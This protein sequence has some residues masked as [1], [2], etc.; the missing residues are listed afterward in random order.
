M[1]KDGEITVAT[2]YD[3]MMGQFGV[4]RGLGGEYPKDYD[5][6]NQPFTPAWQENIPA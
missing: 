5:D 4:S 3:L 1:T 6:Y 2:V